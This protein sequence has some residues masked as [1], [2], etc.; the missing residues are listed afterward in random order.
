MGI[1]LISI[2]L[3]SVTAI[4]TLASDDTNTYDTTVM[5]SHT[6]SVA[7]DLIA[8]FTATHDPNRPLTIGF[9]DES[10]GEPVPYMWGTK[11]G[12]MTYF[13]GFGDKTTSIEKNPVHPFKEPGMYKVYLRIKNAEGQ[14]SKAVMFI[15]VKW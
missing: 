9:N 11:Y 4:T 1:V 15:N 8:A 12:L 7:P 3:L 5:K 6:E 2:L 10:I 13:W 14:V